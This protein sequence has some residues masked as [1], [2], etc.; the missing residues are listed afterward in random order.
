MSNLNPVIVT[1]NTKRGVEEVEDQGLR[2]SAGELAKLPTYR[3]K[4]VHPEAAMER[5]IATEEGDTYKAAVNTGKRIALHRI[6]KSADKAK[7][8]QRKAQKNK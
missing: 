1:V 7:S 8:V 5:F 3:A 6:A 4:T 2:E